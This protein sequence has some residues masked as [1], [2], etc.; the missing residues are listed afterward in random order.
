MND[1]APEIL[2]RS[3]DDLYQITSVI[4]DTASDAIITIDEQ[5]MM[6][7]ANRAAENIFG[8]SHPELIG[9]PLTM[10]MAD[11]LRHLHH[12]DVIETRGLHKDGRGIPL[13]LSLGEFTENGR[14]FFTGIAR[15]ITE[16]RRAQDERTQVF[17]RELRARH[18]VETAID[19]MA[20]VQTVTDVALA[21]LSLDEMLAEM[22]NRV[23]DAMNVDT[24][25]ILLLE[26]SGDELLAWAAKGLEEEV[27]LGI[28]VPVGAG[29]AGQVAAR[30]SPVRIDDIENANVLNP[31]LREKGI[32]SLLGVPLL[33]E[34]R[35]IGVIHV[36]KLTPYLFTED[37]TRLLQL[38]ADRIALAVDNTRL[39]EEERDARREAEAASRAKDEFLTMLSH[40]LRTPLTPIIGWIHMIR[41]GMVPEQEAEHGLSVI[42]RNSHALKRLINDLLD[43]SAI[44]SGKMRME[45]LSVELQA[46][47]NEAVETVRPLAV[48][49]GIQ[50]EVSFGNGQGPVVVNGDRTR[51]VQAFW[52]LLNN[53]IKFTFSGE[54]FL[55][56]ESSVDIDNLIRFCVEDTGVG[57]PAEKLDRLF[58]SFSQL[59]ASTNRRFGGT[60]LELVDDAL[61]GDEF[62]DI[63]ISDQNLVQQDVAAAMIVGV[64]ETRHDHHAIGLI[65]A[66]LGTG[67]RFHVGG[68]AEAGVSAAVQPLCRG[69]RT[70][71]W[72]P[73]R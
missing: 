23:H 30:K 50:L 5:G 65:G 64:V 4:A 40:E 47:L 18:E 60:G 37:D 10:L 9:Q 54:V 62:D 69:G 44:I 58:R 73:C 56:V 61:D 17:D 51:L 28:R 59:D 46:A 63:R 8:Y 21:H 41:S 72:G 66:R 49:S 42:E 1:S 70:P 52:N 2:K 34:G 36:G 53:A 55:R 71:L 48:D 33:V 27:E 11:Y 45:K 15:D 31:I 19:R 67:Q 39:F 3:T 13:E 43:M 16:R 22:L 12:A 57:I 7:F 29:F 32:R 24:V 20:R 38:V 35:V 14:R 25:A 26:P 6:L 68:A